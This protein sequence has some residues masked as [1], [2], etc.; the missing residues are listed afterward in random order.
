MQLVDQQVVDGGMQGVRFRFE[1]LVGLGG[2]R[3]G[4]A[5]HQNGRYALPGG[6]RNHGF[7][8]C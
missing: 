1:R 5:G 8:P 3:L 6:Q 7:V 2:D 4:A